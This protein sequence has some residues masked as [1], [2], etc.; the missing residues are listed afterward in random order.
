MS[1]TIRFCYRF[2]GDFT[3]E[4]TP[5]PIPNTAVKLSRADGTARATAWESRSSPGLTS[6]GLANCQPAFALDSP[7][8]T[9][10]LSVGRF[11]TALPQ[12]LTA[13][14]ART[15]LRLQTESAAAQIDRIALRDRYLKDNRPLPISMRLEEHH[16]LNRPDWAK[17]LHQAA[18]ACQ[19]KCLLLSLMTPFPPGRDR[20]VLGKKRS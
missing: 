12:K 5:V 8:G 1:L 9:I 18:M 13:A 16:R 14:T 17:A 2:L 10:A 4:V 11:M 3:G 7:S 15:I 19:T 20:P 6:S